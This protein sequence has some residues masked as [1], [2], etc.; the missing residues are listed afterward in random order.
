M[1]DKRRFDDSGTLLVPDP[2]PEMFELEALHGWVVIRKVEQQ[3]RIKDGVVIPGGGK[4]SRGIVV[5]A[6]T[7][8]GLH[9]GDEVIFTNFSILVEDLEEITGDKTLQL[10]RHEEVYVRLRKVNAHRPV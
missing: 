1:E 2:E 9:E 7:E 4:S 10:V 6:P 8:T 5:A 3:E